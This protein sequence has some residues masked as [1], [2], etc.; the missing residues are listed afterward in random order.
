MTLGD[1]SGS[2]V[3][4]VDMR[5]G[6]LFLGEKGVLESSAEVVVVIGGTGSAGLRLDLGVFH[7]RTKLSSALSS[8]NKTSGI[9]ASIAMSGFGIL[10]YPHGRRRRRR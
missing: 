10:Q 2:L 1:G 7:R 8:S 9:P 3:G 4:G 6:N 5:G